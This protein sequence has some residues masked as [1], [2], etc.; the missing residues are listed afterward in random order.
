VTSVESMTP[1]DAHVQTAPGEDRDD[2]DRALLRAAEAEIDQRVRD[3]RAAGLYP[4][5]L[6]A[7]LDAYFATIARHLD[8]R[9]IDADLLTE[10]V[11]IA[12]VRSAL[13]PDRIITDSSIPLGAG[14]HRAVAKVVSRQT[15][16]VIEQVNEALVAIVEALRQCDVLMQQLAT[17]EHVGLASIA[18]AAADRAAAFE[19]VSARVGR[20]EKELSHLRAQLGQAN[21]STPG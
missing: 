2:D 7:E 18:S 9:V 11:R 3:R 6:E 15:Q 4:D 17:H 16:G 13:H 5:G 21:G 12:E 14:I 19:A 8:E 20:L 10:S 1:G